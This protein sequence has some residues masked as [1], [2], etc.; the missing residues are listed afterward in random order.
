MLFY[1]HVL[2]LY[3]S[4]NFIINEIIPPP[5]FHF[6]TCIPLE[7][8]SDGICLWVPL[9]CCSLYVVGDCLSINQYIP[10]IVDIFLK[11][12]LYMLNYRIVEEFK[13]FSRHWISANI[14]L[15]KLYQILL[16][17]SV[18]VESCVSCITGLFHF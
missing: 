18:L 11:R 8:F 2:F 14:L 12:V 10:S 5:P 13:E 4:F 6:C 3:F 15:T 17:E 9:G 1:S 16:M 7:L